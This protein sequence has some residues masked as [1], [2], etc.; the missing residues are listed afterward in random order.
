MRVA[1]LRCML[2][3]MLCCNTAKHR[4]HSAV[5]RLY[6]SFLFLISPKLYIF[7]EEYSM[8]F[9]AFST[10]IDRTLGAKPTVIFN[11]DESVFFP[12]VPH[13]SFAEICIYNRKNAFPILSMEVIDTED[14]C[15]RDLTDFVEGL[16]YIYIP[17][18]ETPSISNIISAWCVVHSIPLNREKLLVRYIT[19]NGDEMTVSPIDTTPIE[20]EPLD[21]MNRAPPSP[22]SE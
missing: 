17:D 7:F 10:R 12:Y 4:L 1:S 5:R 22:P 18:M 16:R 14:R 15:V 2:S 20:E 3:T 6:D 19:A 8:P 9:P 11:A 13:K 21:P